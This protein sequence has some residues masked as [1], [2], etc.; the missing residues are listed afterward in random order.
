MLC[1]PLGILCGTSLAT[2]AP[3]IHYERTYLPTLYTSGVNVMA[4]T[5]QMHK[6]DSHPMRK[7]QNDILIDPSGCSPSNGLPHGFALK[8]KTIGN[9]LNEL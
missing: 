6:I 4:A 7:I 8:I 3:F 1:F 9:E 5:I 2:Y